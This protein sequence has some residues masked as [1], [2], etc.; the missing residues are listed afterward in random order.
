MSVMMAVM[1]MVM[2]MFVK[3]KHST[4]REGHSS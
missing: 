3:E 2:T 1:V 4:R